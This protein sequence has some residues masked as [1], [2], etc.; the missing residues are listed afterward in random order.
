GCGAVERAEHP[1]LT[2]LDDREC[3]GGGDPLDEPSH[4]LRGRVEALQQYLLARLQPCRV[5]DEHVGELVYP[6]IEHGIPLVLVM[7]PCGPGGP[8][9][10]E[11]LSRLRHPAFRRALSVPRS[12]LHR[13][14]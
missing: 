9:D 8:A 5:V 12:A 3:A 11:L 14:R 6:W 1:V 4:D 10:A 13:A 7:M 2:R